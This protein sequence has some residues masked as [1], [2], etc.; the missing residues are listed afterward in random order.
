MKLLLAIFSILIFPY[1]AKASRIPELIEKTTV[2]LIKNWNDDKNLK[3]WFP[4]QVITVPR[5]TKLFGGGCKGSNEGFDVAGSYY[6]PADHTIILDPVQL[7]TFIKAFGN[8]SVAYVVAH[9]FAHALQNALKIRL[10]APNHELQADCLAGYFIQKGNKELGV[11]RENILEMS[12]V[13]YAIGDK[14]HGTGAQ[15]AYALLSGMGRVDADCSY[16]SIDKL[17]KGD[18]D[19]PLYKAFTKTRGSGKSVDL[20]STP[21]KKDA[22]GLL[23]INLKNSKIDSRFK[24]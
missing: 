17:V 14:T 22:S 20:E 7:K 23:G 16:S 13:A 5:G 24:L 10:K 12:S 18:I 21:Y 8:S 15:R 3:N 2:Y 19:D 6:C 9:E 4:P 1:E 11:T